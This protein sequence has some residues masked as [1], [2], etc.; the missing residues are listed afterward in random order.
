MTVTDAMAD[1]LGA[2]VAVATPS[3]RRSH[4]TPAAIAQ[5]GDI[6]T[7]PTTTAYTPAGTA[8]AAT[9][10]S[11]LSGRAPP[12]PAMPKNSRVP[13]PPRSAMAATKGQPPR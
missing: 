12:C 7:A 9:Y 11:P 8:A 6:P 5:A 2:T 13:T 4:T 1:G 3:T 10:P